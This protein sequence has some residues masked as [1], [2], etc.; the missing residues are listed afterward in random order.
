MYTLP[1]IHPQTGQ[2]MVN[3]K[4]HL[5]DFCEEVIDELQVCA[6]QSSAG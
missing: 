5:T 4:E 3:E 2:P 6:R 1:P